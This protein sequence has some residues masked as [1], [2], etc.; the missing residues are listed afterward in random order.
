MMINML[1]TV[2]TMLDRI[3]AM[4]KPCGANISM[5][6]DC[7]RFSFSNQKNLTVIFVYFN[8]IK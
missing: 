7:Q 6:I 5:E 8:M 1:T 4:A 2:M 3:M